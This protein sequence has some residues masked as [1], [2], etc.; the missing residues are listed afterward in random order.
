MLLALDKKPVS[1]IDQEI[2]D[3]IKT[4]LKKWN[5]PRPELGSGSPGYGGLYPKEGQI[6]RADLRPDHVGKDATLA[7]AATDGLGGDKWSNSLLYTHGASVTGW[8]T[9]LNLTIDEDVYI[10]LEGIFD[11]SVNPVLSALQFSVAGMDYPVMNVRDMYIFKPK[12]V[13]WF[14]MPFVVPEKVNL[15]VYL[16]YSGDVATARSTTTVGSEMLGF[17]GEVIAKQAYLQKQV[18]A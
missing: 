13:G 1:I 14:P 15:K 11:I 16:R 17:I 7:T 4:A 9:D 8:V 10:V 18:Q 6:G 12:G 5:M 3:T 2:E